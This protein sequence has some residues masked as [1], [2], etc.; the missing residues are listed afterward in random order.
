MRPLAPL[1]GGV[2]VD[3]LYRG[4]GIDVIGVDTA[5]VLAGVVGMTA[6][7]HLSRCE[8]VGPTVRGIDLFGYFELT[9]SALV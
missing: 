5:G 2:E 4:D 3:V 7:Q 1:L 8:F 6:S 9:V